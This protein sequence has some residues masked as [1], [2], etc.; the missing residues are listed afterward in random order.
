LP[1]RDPRLL[2]PGTLVPLPALLLE[3][4]ARATGARR[5]RRLLRPH[6]RLPLRR[7]DGE[8]RAEAPAPPPG[9]LMRFEDHVRRALESLP[10]ELGKAVRTRELSIEDEH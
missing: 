6:R 1:D 8:A 2:V 5:R 3:L 4:R 7:A 10:P 9:L